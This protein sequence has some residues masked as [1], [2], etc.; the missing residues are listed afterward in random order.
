ML[1]VQQRQGEQIGRPRV[2]DR[3]GFNAR[4]NIILERLSAGEISRRWAAKELGIGYPTLKRLLGKGPEGAPTI[5]PD[6][7]A[8]QEDIFYHY[9][10]HR[11]ETDRETLTAPKPPKGTQ[12]S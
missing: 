10:G 1:I 2:I 8:P 12:L 7:G 5:D 4:Y 11:A 6:R 3:R 9:K